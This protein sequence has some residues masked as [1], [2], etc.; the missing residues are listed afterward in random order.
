MCGDAPSGVD[1]SSHIDA[2]PKMRRIY[3]DQ[4]HAAPPFPGVPP[5]APA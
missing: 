3:I 4:H 5:D 2:I 1:G